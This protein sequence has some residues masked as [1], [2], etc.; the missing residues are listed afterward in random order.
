MS[1]YTKIRTKKGLIRIFLI[2]LHDQFQRVFMFELQQHIQKTIK[3]FTLPTSL[4]VVKEI[5]AQHA[6]TH[7]PIVD[8]GVFLGNIALDDAVTINSNSTLNDNRMVF[9]PFFARNTMDWF[10]VL[11]I[12]SKHETNLVPVLS[13]KNHYLGY[14]WFDDILDYFNQT[15]FLKESGN[16]IVVEKNIFDYSLSQVSQIVEVNNAKLL[17]VFVSKIK[18]NNAQI[19]LKMIGTN[20]TEIIQSFRRYG[21]EIVSEHTEDKYLTELKDRSAYLDKYLNI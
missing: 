8:Q 3:P 14:I 16:V 11:E 13:P 15:P 7:L 18:D 12:F 21:Y 5:F 2:I 10:E 4:A 19:T 9:L 20:L 6:F 17:G 1:F